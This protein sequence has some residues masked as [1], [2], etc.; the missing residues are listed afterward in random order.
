MVKNYTD[1]QLLS[2][3]KSLPNFKSIPN[4]Y[5]ILGVRSNEDTPDAFDDKFYIFKGEEFITVTSG[6]TNPGV[7]ILKG[8]FKRYNNVGAA[9]VVAD[10][11]YYGVWKKG[12]HLGRTT[13]LLQLGAKIK[14]HRD[15]NLNDKSEATSNIVEGYFGINFHPNTYDFNATK[16]N[17]KIGGWSAGCQV[18]NNMAKYR[19]ILNLMPS[20]VKITYC[21]LNEF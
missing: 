6:T 8:G 21:L 19:E 17:S 11:W 16:T 5:W 4:D 9:V 13:A 12:K 10:H 7:S 3:V 14:V 1:E 20:G 2:R 15:G 18:V